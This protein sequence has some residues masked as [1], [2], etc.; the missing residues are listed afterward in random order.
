MN[1]IEYGKDEYDFPAL[2]VLGC[3]DAIHIGHRELI[4]K[5]QLQA[6]I[7]GLDLGV[8]LF[9]NGKGD[10]T[11]YTLEERL[12]ILEK[13]KVKFALVIDFTEEF[14]NIPAEEF[15]RSVESKVNVKAYMSGKDFRFGAKAKGK[16]ATLKAYADDEEN[17]VWYLPVKDVCVDG[18][19]VSTT[20]IKEKLANGD[21]A[22]ANALL[23]EEFYVS[24][25]V[26]KGAGRGAELGFP[27]ANINYAEEKFRIKQGVYRVK[28]AIDGEEY[29]GIAN[30]GG[31]PTFGDESVQLE[32]HFAGFDGDLYGRTVEVRFL[33]YIRDITAF[34]S[35]EELKA[36]LEEDKAALVADIEKA[37]EE[38]ASSGEEIAKDGGEN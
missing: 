21:V 10:K 9:K 14:K 5:A 23:G 12:A 3:F 27:T 33:G 6:K 2:L 17:G 28:S 22:G 1:V 18:E 35:A 4:K 37:A 25:E 8:M 13:Y 26:V 32:V 36:Q 20:Q 29:Y 30:Y 7:N 24:G 31:R 19:K 15:L 38:S 16:S 34:S 11:V